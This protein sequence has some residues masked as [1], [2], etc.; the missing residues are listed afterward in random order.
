MDKLT[1]QVPTVFE[2]VARVRYSEVDHRGRMTPPALINAFQ[3]CS[4]LQSELLGL[5]MSH[6]KEQRRAWVL[7]H[8]LIAVDRYP[9]LCEEVTTG[10]FAASF[11]GIR[12]IRC[13]YLRDADGRIIARGQGTYAFINLETGRPERPGADQTDPYGTHEPLKMPS[14]SRHIALPDRLEPRGPVTVRRH[15]IDTNE[16]VNNSQYVQM[17]LEFAPRDAEPHLLRVDYR[18]AAALGDIMYPQVS[19]GSDR[20]VVA[21]CDKSGD[22]FA[23]VEM[24]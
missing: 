15:H 17:A 19:V 2:T 7:S 24:S 22:R 14:E 18:R 1:P 11:R 20:T 9:E 16:H 13:F 21:L 10:T 23:V 5:G 12:A 3:D 8:W 4:A 6:L